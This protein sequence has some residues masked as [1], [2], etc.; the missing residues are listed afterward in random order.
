MTNWDNAHK[1]ELLVLTLAFLMPMLIMSLFLLGGNTDTED[2]VTEDEYSKNTYTL[3]PEI[4]AQSAMVIELNTGKV[5]YS[6]EANVQRPIASIT[7]LMTTLVAS[8]KF[9]EAGVTRVRIN[10]EHL[11]AFGDSGLLSGQVWNI[12]DLIDFTL[13]T[14]SNDGAKAL[15]LSAFGT[16]TSDFVSEMNSLSQELGLAN[17]FFANETGL[18]INLDTEAGAISSAK[19][20]SKIL[21]Y[22]TFHDLD[23]F[24][25]STKSSKII[26]NEENIYTVENTNKSINSLP[27]P[28]ISKTGYTDIAGGNLAVVVDFGLNNPISVVVL[29]STLEEREVDV[30]KIFEEVSKYYSSNIRK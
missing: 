11:K 25:N 13:I 5:L 8:E 24:S 16:K 3:N 30:M 4:K 27:N 19:D 15:A 23:V 20:I 2:L 29:G 1:K 26:F 28:L 6:K 18:D 7:K 21:K 22:I 12:K 17:T 9:K 10:E 14:S